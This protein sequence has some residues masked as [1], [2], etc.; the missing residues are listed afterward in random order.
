M[1]TAPILTS[2]D[3]PTTLTVPDNFA[4]LS[5][6]REAR[7]LYIDLVMEFND[8]TTVSQALNDNNASASDNAA[9]VVAP[10][11]R[12]M[13]RRSGALCF[14][15]QKNAVHAWGRQTAS[16]GHAHLILTAIFLIILIFATP[17]AHIFL[18][19]PQLVENTRKRDE[20]KKL[21]NSA[22]ADAIAATSILDK[23][24]RAQ[25]RGG[26]FVAN[27]L[28]VVEHDTLLQ[29]YLAALERFGIV[30]SMFD[31]QPALNANAKL[32]VQQ[33]RAQIVTIELQGRFDV[34]RDIRNIFMRAV[35]HVTVL[36]ETVATIDQTPDVKIKSRVMLAARSPKEAI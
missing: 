26:Q 12:L 4:E 14:M 33:I 22:Q 19:T 3:L 16:S 36:E 10:V 34:Y 9:G 30:V 28:P 2:A 21:Q 5:L 17:L 7:S 6:S 32:G 24:K 29:S 27:L 31:I 8:T 25:H 20:I 13:R 18:L 35:R 11:A 1:S 15:G 23:V